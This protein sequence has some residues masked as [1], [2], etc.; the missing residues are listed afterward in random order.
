VPEA[1]A[2]RREPA[3]R[4][5]ERFRPRRERGAVD[6][7]ASVRPEHAGDLLQR[8]SRRA[9]ERDEREAIEDAGVEQAP[10][11]PSPD[12]ADQALFVVVAQ[13][14][15]RDAGPAG[16]LRGVEYG[17]GLDLKRA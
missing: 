14:G 2:E 12:R 13:R 11:A 9:A 7:G 10:E 4:R 16:N 8:E 6:P 15:R 3:D 1:L 5:V 17:Q